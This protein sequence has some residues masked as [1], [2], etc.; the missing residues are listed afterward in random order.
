VTILDTVEEA[1]DALEELTS[2]SELT[3]N[4]AGHVDPDDETTCHQ[5]EP[6][7][8]FKSKAALAG[9]S[10]THR[11][12]DTVEKA[13][14]AGGKKVPAKKSPG[15]KK[16]TSPRPK[17][18]TKPSTP[19]PA[20]LSGVEMIGDLVDGAGTLL[21]ERNIDVPVGRLLQL[22]APLLA[23]EL[24]KA[25]AGH[26]VDRHLL[27]PAIRTE[28][29]WRVVGELLEAPI[30]VLLAERVPE[31]RD[32][33]YPRL[34]K[35]LRRQLPALVKRYKEMA[36]EQA[37]VD[38]AVEELSQLS[39]DMARIFA[40]GVDPVDMLIRSLFNAAAPDDAPEEGTT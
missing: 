10:W 28:A 32:I 9:H 31:M 5:C 36:D 15:A 26:F 18:P 17:K 25:I 13:K 16:P 6:P 20:R 21:T 2:P 34:H 1:L 37:E 19:A 35:N 23:P 33:V 24:D 14:G 30:L 38:E 40:G 39:P 4:L 27:Q 12:R 11:A 8:V 29:R 7:R 3:P 22:E